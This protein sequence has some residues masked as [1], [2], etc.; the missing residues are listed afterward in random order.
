M[1]RMGASKMTTIETLIQRL[2]TVGRKTVVGVCMVPIL[3]FC[4]VAS[5]DTFVLKTGVRVDGVIM[6]EK[7]GVAHVKVGDKVM[8]MRTDEMVRVE[9]NDKEGGFDIESA[10]EAAKE[11]ERQRTLE[12][13]LTTEQRGAV[14]RAM[15]CLLSPDPLVQQKGHDQLIELAKQ[16]RVFLYLAEWL[17]GMLPRFIPG[18]MGV[19]CELDWQKARPYVREQCTSP[20]AAV[21]AAAIDLLANYR[22]NQDVG[23]I[24]RGLAD[25]LPTVQVA[26]AE[27]L[28]A[29]GADEATPALIVCLEDTDLRV[30]NAAR[31][32]L[33]RIWKLDS[34][35]AV[36]LNSAPAWQGYWEQHK[37][38]VPKPLHMAALRPL[39]PEGTEF[40][41]E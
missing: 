23:T 12:T 2:K 6:H 22:S 19:L 33:E 16:G 40:R 9:K 37:D 24:A 15:G 25:H 5:T 28:A 1:S 13:G 36:S 34:E 20:D 31:H 10:I 26:A 3:A 4:T 11:R 7:D 27:A 39:V 17:P 32:A 8:L 30:S 41:D 29:L 35:T 14:K 21:R 18:V 38:G